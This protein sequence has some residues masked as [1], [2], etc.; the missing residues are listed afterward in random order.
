MKENTLVTIALVVSFVGVFSLFFASQLYSFKEGP[1]IVTNI[2]DGDTLDVDNGD[3]VRLAGIDAPEI[4]TC[5]SSQATGALQ[6]LVLNKEVYLEGDVDEVGK[7]GRVLSYVFVDNFHVN[8]FLVENGYVKVFDK[9]NSTTSKYEELKEAEKIAKSKNIGVWSCL[10]QECLFI[11]N[12]ETKV[13]HPVDCHWAK[14]IKEENKVCISSE[15]DLVE[16]TASKG[17]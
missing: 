8:L 13:Y 14:K 16:Y 17:C 11:G 12:K 7:Y 15:S 1:F 3:R 2:V 5:Y 10:Q 6:Q 4:G 9:Y